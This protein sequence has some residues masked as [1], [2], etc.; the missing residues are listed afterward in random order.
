MMMMGLGLA[1]LLLE[2]QTMMKDSI[3]I[4]VGCCHE[5]QHIGILLMAVVVALGQRWRR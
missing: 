5:L 1:F 3:D 4:F 2:E